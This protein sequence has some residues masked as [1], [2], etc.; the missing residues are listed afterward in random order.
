MGSLI[1]RHHLDLA[2]TD[3]QPTALLVMTHN[4][5]GLRYFCKTSRL[6]ELKY[7]KGS[8][9]YWKRHLKKHGRDI[10]VETLGIYFDKEH[11]LA[12]AKEFCEQHQIGSNSEWA[13]LIPENGL[14]GA[15]V[16]KAHPMFG[17]PS[18]CIGQKRPWVGKKGTDNPM[19]GK[20]SPMRGIPKPKGKDSPLYGRKRP[21]GGGKPSKPVVCLTDGSVFASVSE[22]AR[23]YNGNSTTISKCCLGKAKTAYGME[24]AYKESL[25]QLA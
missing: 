12:V 7:Y 18:P 15:P 6:N 17:K 3:F 8:G 21:E 9:V 24:W 1:L 4:V 20:P 5:T 19:W 23:K 10:A 14:D 16:G 13:N 22:A 2:M 11:C 25:C